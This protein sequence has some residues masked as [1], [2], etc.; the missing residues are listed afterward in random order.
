MK[1]QLEDEQKTEEFVDEANDDDTIN[2][3]LAECPECLNLYD[4]KKITKHIACHSSS[5]SS[6]SCNK[7]DYKTTT[8]IRLD[9]HC[10]K[11]HGSCVPSKT[12]LKKTKLTKR[13]C[14]YC[15]I[16][17]KNLQ[18]H[19]KI[20]HSKTKRFYCDQCTYSCYF[21]TKIARHLLK[22]IPKFHREL[23]SC[24]EV[25]CQFVCSRKDALK[26]HILTIHQ[27]DRLKS[28]L[29]SHCNKTFFN[30]SQLN[31][32]MR[33]VHEKEK[34]Y[35]CSLCG[36]SFFNAKDLSM[37]EVRHFEKKEKCSKCEALFFCRVDLNRHFKNKHTAAEIKCIHENCERKFHTNAKLKEHV[38][39]R[40]E[41]LKEF[42]C[43]Y[44]ESSFSQYN[45]L[46]RH[47]DSVH[48]ALRIACAIPNCTFSVSRKDKYKN[49]LISHHKCI[50]DKTR[51][52]IL[53]N[54]KYE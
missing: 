41:K 32:H 6:H 17:V 7:C 34:N 49:H 16:L 54:V 2:E 26:A 35:T 3:D 47:I 9:N 42:L 24:T 29:C 31:I 1:Q 19:Y 48:K 8:T 4:A 36:K 44:C 50:D 52:S 10:R 14:I 45:N 22:H 18:E 28:F 21:K 20:T 46:K 43:S 38:K 53:K 25:G 39:T 37:H 40:H 23:F 13:Q 30:K 27:T 33:A 11:V 5:K 12:T 51:D 15:G